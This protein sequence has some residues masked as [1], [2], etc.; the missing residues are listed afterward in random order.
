LSLEISD[1]FDTD[2]KNP[3]DLRNQLDNISHQQSGDY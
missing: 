1:L 3:A 2:K